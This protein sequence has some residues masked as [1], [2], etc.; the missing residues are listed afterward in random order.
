MFD[1]QEWFKEALVLIALLTVLWV[2]ISIFVRFPLSYPVAVGAVILIV[3]RIH[4]KST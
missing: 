3:W 4:K 1:S 2:V